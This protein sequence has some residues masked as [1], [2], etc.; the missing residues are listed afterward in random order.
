MDYS[1]VEDTNCSIC[2]SNRYSI[3]ADK[4]QFEMPYRTVICR[5]CGFIYLN[6]IPV[7]KELNNFYT[8]EYKKYYG[9]PVEITD[10]SYKKRGYEIYEFIKEFTST[11]NKIL[12]IGA[13]GGG[14]LLG[15]SEKFNT[16][17]LAAVEP[18][19]SSNRSLLSGKI[20]VLGEFYDEEPLNIK[21]Y[22]L[23]ILSHI[24]EHFY[25]PKKVLK[26][27]WE[28]TSDEAIIYIAIPSLSA[29]DQKKYSYHSAL[30]DYWFRIVHLSYFHK[31]NILDLLEMTGWN[32]MKIHEKGNGELLIVVKKSSSLNE[33]REIKNVYDLHLEEV[34]FYRD[35]NDL[36][37]KNRRESHG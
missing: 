22:D 15:L 24:L 36:K 1:K 18:G 21:E 30:E 6:P 7:K 17:Y 19:G 4:V 31:Q 14:N 8:Y 25:N 29:I 10:L 5:E 34:N 11:V 32:M 3:I 2:N 28:E 35:S 33:N 9:V 27:L 13:G 26:K 37:T 20:N 16:N 12:E 23:I